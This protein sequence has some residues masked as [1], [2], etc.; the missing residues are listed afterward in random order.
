MN[1]SLRFQ[2]KQS[3]QLSL[4]MWLPL[5]QAPLTELET[6]FREK[7]YENPFLEVN[8][9]FESSSFTNASIGGN[10]ESDDKRGFIENMS[11]YHESIYDKVQ[12]QIDDHLFPTPNSKKIA[13]EILFYINNQGYFEGDIEFIAQ[14][15][16]T[17]TEFVESI[18]KRFAYLEP[19]GV[20]AINMEE[21]FLFQLSQMEIEEELSSFT[22]KLIE[23]FKKMDRFSTHHLFNDAKG[24]IKRFSNP[25]AVDYLEDQPSVVPDF[26]VEVGEDINIKINHS[27]YPDIVVSD[28]FKT[29]NSDLKDK[30]KE[31]RDLV[32]LLELRKSTLYKLILV[33]VEK[34]IGFFIGSELK[35]LTMDDVARELG[36]EESTIS[37]AV[38][39]K[40]IKCD[41]GI[42][43]LKYFFTNKV[44]SGLSSSE[45]K[46]FLSEVIEQENHDKPYTD[47]DLVDMVMQRYNISMVRRTITKYRKI[48]DIPSSKDRKKIYKMQ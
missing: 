31:A 30:M 29:K 5:L 20:G 9:H 10:P 21:S 23:N 40:Y 22:K 8:T 34:Q 36:F 32:N 1:T 13:N 24:I 28:P 44:A 41:K 45:I 4:K 3:L 17:T 46:N 12:E 19:T 42:F 37:R 16:N 43:A 11:I 26:F 33:I 35:P 39:N 25:P 14:K 48:L 38:A 27:Y 18:R 6:H 15:C 2:Q 47:Q 7:A